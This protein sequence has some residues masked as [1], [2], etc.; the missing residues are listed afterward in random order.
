MESITDQYLSDRRLQYAREHIPNRVFYLPFDYLFNVRLGTIAKLLSWAVIYI[1]PTAVYSWLLADNLGISTADF[2]LSYLVLLLAVF[3]VYECGYIYNDT[4]ATLKEKYPTV[5][6]YHHNLL[7]FLKHYYDIIITRAA[8]TLAAV[9]CYVFLNWHTDNLLL[10]IVALFFIPFV[11]TF[12]NRT[13]NKWNV[14][15]YP[16]LVLSRYVV[17]LVPFLQSELTGIAALMLILCFPLC[18]AIERFSMPRH[19]FPLIKKIIP[20]EDSKTLFRVGYYLLLIAVAAPLLF[21]LYPTPTATALLAPAA[22]IALMRLII[23]I[24]TLHH[25]PQNYLRG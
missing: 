19:R 14:L 11:F 16:F 2:C 21:I 5:R 7:Y 10:T 22:L 1:V 4:T 8:I 24:I 9:T 17:F 18:N 20:D 25:R 15:I 13:R 12:Y 3:N 23:Y 6:L